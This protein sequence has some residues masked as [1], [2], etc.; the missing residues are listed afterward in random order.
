MLLPSD[1][2][3]LWREYLDEFPD[4]APPV[5]A[6]DTETSG[7]H[8]DDGARIS[9]V[10]VAW[11]GPNIAWWVSHV[12][13]EHGEYLDGVFTAREEPVYGPPGAPDGSEM[14]FSLAWPFDQGVHGTDKPENVSGQGV[15]FPDT[16][17]LPREEWVAFLE[18]LDLLGATGSGLIFQNA[19]FDLMMLLA[20]VRRWPG[21]G[22]DAL[23]LFRWDVMNGSVV[24]FPTEVTV[25]RRGEEVPTA[26]LKPVSAWLWGD[27]ETG[28]QEKI[29]S[30]LRLR[31]LPSGRWD[32]MPWD[33]IG[34]YA[35]DDARKTLRLY[36]R[37]LR[38]LVGRPELRESIERRNRVTAMLTRVERRG[39]PFDVDGAGRVSER[40]R[41]LASELAGRLPFEPSLPAA[42]RYWFGGV[43]E[44]GLGLPAYGE[45][46][47]GAPQLTGP[48]VARMVSHGVEHA[49]TWRDLQ[50]VESVNSRWYEGWGS[51]CGS[52]G[53]LRPSFRQ[54]GTV[55]GRFSVERVQLQ[56]IPH[57]YRL[58]N[59]KVLDGLPTPRALIGSGVPE[60]WSMWEFDLAN[61]E[62]RVAALFAGC[63]PMLDMFRR[64][65]DLHGATAK[66]LFNA[67]E[68]S[69]EWDQL[70]AVA[71]RANFSFVFGVGWETFQESVRDEAGVDLSDRDAQRL[72]RDWNALYPQYRLAIKS[73]E[74]R[75]R[76]RQ[77]KT[78]RGWLKLV[79]GERRWFTGSEDAHKAFNQRVQAN[80]AQ[81]GIDWWLG[82]EEWSRS[83]LA[84]RV[85][86][87]VDTRSGVYVG[88]VG[89]V[90]MV[91]DSVVLLLP[92][93]S[94]EAAVGR[95]RGIG[96]EVWRGMFPG[97]E[98]RVDA[99]IW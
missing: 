16:S 92:D 68:A 27:V 19:K 15:L 31:K 45:T 78:G 96:E 69:R 9:A 60:G 18:W 73:H 14:V 87:G 98:G 84:D 21:L 54:N 61:A 36:Y 6:L 86:D 11:G 70:R 55:S 53:R 58:G 99:S 89:V 82:A 94:S 67:S 10:S 46:P 28:E 49:D 81:L 34:V 95:V 56:A 50:K 71:K 52:D 25:K 90:L 74:E 24:L 41:G 85:V 7:L 77:R 39:L 33:V 8:P 12:A 48:I 66:S 80:L 37:Q 57:D 38:E 97:I 2:L 35:D 44:G 63:T 4:D 42:K 65:E 29:K 26:A 51:M 47:S 64:G 13:G 79:N 1:V 72:V 17:N 32:L 93:D 43:E 59:F 88:G 91:H 20:G 3:R 76:V 83:W 22:Y 23:D 40:L 75:V 62:A 30:Y 5:V